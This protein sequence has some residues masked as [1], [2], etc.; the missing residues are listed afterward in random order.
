M[1]R[2]V[3]TYIIDILSSIQGDVLIHAYFN[4]ED[5]IIWNA[6]K[7]K[8]PQLKYACQTILEKLQNGEFES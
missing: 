8:I 3:Q 1:R 5:E 4:I 7:W 6:V 2:N